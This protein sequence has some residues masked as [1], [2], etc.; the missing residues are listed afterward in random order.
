MSTGHSN[1]LTDGVRVR[2]ASKFLPEESSPDHAEWL[3]LYRVII[4]NEGAQD[5][6]LKQRHW[7]IKDAENRVQEVRGE[8]V[9]GETPVIAPGEQYEYFSRCPLKTSWGTMEGSYTLE[10]PDGER[11]DVPIGRFFLAPTVA[12]IEEL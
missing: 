8:G 2:V 9:V 6:Q 10:R 4:G 7:I 1:T 5:V 11:F 12:P 3:F